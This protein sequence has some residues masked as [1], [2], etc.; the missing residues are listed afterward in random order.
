MHARRTA[1]QARLDELGAMFGAGEIDSGQLRSGTAEL[2]G[3]L[4]EIDRILADAAA[5]SPAVHLLDGDPDE[6]E[7]R[8]AALSP[9][10]K[11]KIVDELMTVT[12][13]PTPR[14]TKAVTGIGHR[15]YVVD[16]RLVALE[17]K[18]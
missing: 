11:G 15:R 2:R 10:M 7:T 9:D 3:R 5:T 6:L 8:W 18:V 17:P 14:G 12:V 13:M 16:R 1:L 4:G